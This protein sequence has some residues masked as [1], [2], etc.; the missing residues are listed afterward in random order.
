MGSYRVRRVYP[1]TLRKPILLRK[2]AFADEREE[3]DGNLKHVGVV[4]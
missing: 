2:N 3:K 4:L 1:S